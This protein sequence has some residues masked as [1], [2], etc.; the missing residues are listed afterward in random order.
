MVLSRESTEDAEAPL[1]GAAGCR[2]AYVRRPSPA[3][4]GCAFLISGSPS[5]H[6][7]SPTERCRTPYASALQAQAKIAVSRLRVLLKM[8][9]KEA[10]DLASCPVTRLSVVTFE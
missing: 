8:G 4:D 2:N 5:R 1:S 10:A 3:G 6:L 7:L 9:E